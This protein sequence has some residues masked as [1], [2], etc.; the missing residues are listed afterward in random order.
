MAGIIK[1]LSKFVRGETETEYLQRQAATSRI[2]ATERAAAFKFREQEALK[3]AESKERLIREAKERKLKA[4]L[5]PPVRRANLPSI[6]NTPFTGTGFG[7]MGGYAP[8]SRTIRR[9]KGKKNRQVTRY[10][11]SPQPQRYDVL[12]I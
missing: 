4:R 6:R 8:S 7:M 1:K 10:V 5:N 11:N 2:R 9:R 3:F 12:G